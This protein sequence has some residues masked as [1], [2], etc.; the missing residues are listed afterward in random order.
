MNINWQDTAILFTDR[1][2]TLGR[3]INFA[4]LAPVMTTDEVID[5]MKRDASRR[6]IARPTETIQPQPMRG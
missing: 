1:Q 4:Y 2:T 5:A 3:L 6:N